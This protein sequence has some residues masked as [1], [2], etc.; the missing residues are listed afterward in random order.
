M[1]ELDHFRLVHKLNLMF[2]SELIQHQAH[3]RASLNSISLISL[4]PETPELGINCKPSKYSTFAQVQLVFQEDIERLKRKE[5]PKRLTP[6]KKLQS[7]M[8]QEAINNSERLPFNQDVK[9]ITSELAINNRLG[10]KVV[11]DVIGYQESTGQLWIIELKSERLRKRLIEQV[12]NFE[13][14]VL[15]N[16]RFFSELLNIYGYSN[17]YLTRET[18]VKAVVWPDKK[19]KADLILKEMKIVEYGYS[20]EYDFQLLK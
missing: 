20:G 12:N 4:N 8:I 17:V 11:T 19:S 3:F 9:F 15:E 13:E 10:K 7:W 18:I 1:K 14:V 16:P 2:N 6:E 5:K